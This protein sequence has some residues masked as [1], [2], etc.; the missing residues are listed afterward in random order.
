MQPG[1]CSGDA[2]AEIGRGSNFLTRAEM[3]ANKR[4]ARWAPPMQCTAVHETARMGVC[5]QPGSRRS[6]AAHVQALP[7]SFIDY[8][9]LYGYMCR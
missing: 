7:R 6:R 5:V 8:L 3:F 9:P 2:A 1:L 4:T